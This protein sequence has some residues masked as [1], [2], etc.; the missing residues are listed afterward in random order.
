MQIINREVYSSVFL[1]WLLAMA[2]VSLGLAGYAWVFVTGPAQAWFIA[3]GLIYF[4]GTFLVTVLGN[5]PMNKRLDPMAPTLGAT[6]EYWRSYAMFWTMWN[7]VRTAAS[8]AASGAFL[9]GAVLYA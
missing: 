4:V 9:V 3:G 2:P 7:H 8:A 5:V 6:Q 1:V